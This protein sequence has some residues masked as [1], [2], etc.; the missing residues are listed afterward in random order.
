MGSNKTL[1]FFVSASEL[2]KLF[3]VANAVNNNSIA[4]QH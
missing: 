3:N 4:L 1:G 2:N